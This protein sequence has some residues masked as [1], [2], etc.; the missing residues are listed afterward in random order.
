MPKISKIFCREVPKFSK[1][2]NFYMPKISIYTN[3]IQSQINGICFF[4][5]NCYKREM[6]SLYFNVLQGTMEKEIKEQ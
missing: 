4:S 5:I 3:Q 1:E 6:R 2:Y